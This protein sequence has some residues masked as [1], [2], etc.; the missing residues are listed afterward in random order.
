MHS[1]PAQPTNQPNQPA[2]MTQYMEA[3]SQLV[4]LV[5]YRYSMYVLLC[6]VIGGVV[7]FANSFS[8]PRSYAKHGAFWQ[9]VDANFERESMIMAKGLANGLI[10]GA[11]VGIVT[12]ISLSLAIANSFT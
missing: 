11:G 12:P 5:M 8:Q 9:R 6:C 1:Q 7:G 10:V 3:V 2:G 4:E